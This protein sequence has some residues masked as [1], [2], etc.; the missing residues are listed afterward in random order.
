VVVEILETN[1]FGPVS[2]TDL[3]AWINTFRLPITTVM[4][5][6]GVGLR[7]FMTYG[8]RETVFIVDLATMRIVRRFNGSVAGIGPS[9]IAQA[10]TEV[11]RLMGG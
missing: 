2:R 5:P 10:V 3:D 8:I 11:M 9:A 6:P 4:D 7:T 1:A